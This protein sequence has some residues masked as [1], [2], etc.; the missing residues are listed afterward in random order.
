MCILF[1]FVDHLHVRQSFNC[2]TFGSIIDIEN[3]NSHLRSISL[4]S[5]CYPYD[6][7]SNCRYGSMCFI[8]VHNIQNY[9]WI[10]VFAAENISV[11]N[12]TDLLTIRG[13]QEYLLIRNIRY[14]Y[15]SLSYRTFLFGKQHSQIDFGLLRG[16]SSTVSQSVNQEPKNSQFAVKCKFDIS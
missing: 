11:T 15:P 5:P 10:G 2:T 9:L 4:L 8:R 12:A 16:H 14:V 7:Y 3:T 13:D 1:I 6:Y